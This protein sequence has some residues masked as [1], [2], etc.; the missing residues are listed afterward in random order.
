MSLSKITNFFRL[1][2]FINLWTCLGAQLCPTLCEPMDC[3]PPGSSVHRIFQARKLDWVAISS[4][5]G[6]S[7]PKDWTSVS[8]ITGGFFT[9]WAAK[10]GRTRSRWVVKC[11]VLFSCSGSQLM[12]LVKRHSPF[13]SMILTSETDEMK[14]L[15]KLLKCSEVWGLLEDKYLKQWLSASEFQGRDSGV[16]RLL[17]CKDCAFVFKEPSVVPSTE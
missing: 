9:N 16:H 10:L 2:I 11:L 4:S 3:S 12:S 17:E 7:W 14:S 13:S 15:L 6:S 1:Q 8:C 5:R